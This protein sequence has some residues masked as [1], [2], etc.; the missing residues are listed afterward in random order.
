M[1]D[2]CANL[3]PNL[4]LV[5]H[6]MYCIEELTTTSEVLGCLTH[7]QERSQVG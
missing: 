2:I 3:E 4:L 1:N 7:I 6:R 5:L